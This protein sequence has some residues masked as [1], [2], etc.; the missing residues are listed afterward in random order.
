MQ[1]QNKK[2]R[3]KQAKQNPG[4]GEL[5]NVFTKRATHTWQHSG[6]SSPSRYYHDGVGDDI[7]TREEEITYLGSILEAN[8]SADKTATNVIKKKVNQRTRF[9]YRISSLVDKNTLKTLTGAPVQGLCLNLM[10]PQH[11]KG[12]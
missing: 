11:L 9:L 5:V 12:P 3:K 2:R 6:D 1:K 7:I 10:V 4:S 8:L